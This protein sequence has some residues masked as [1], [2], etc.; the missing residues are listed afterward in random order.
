MA[1]TP[2][3]INANRLNAQRSTGPKSVEGKD[4]ARRNAL[5]HGLTGGGVVLPGEDEREVAIREAAFRDQLVDEGDALVGALVRQMAIAS[6]RV[7]DDPIGEERRG[8]PERGDRASI[9]SPQPN[10]AEPM[11]T[12]PAER[13]RRQSPDQHRQRHPEFIA[14]RRRLTVRR[15][16]HAAGRQ[17]QRQTNQPGASHRR[18]PRTRVAQNPD[19]SL[20]DKV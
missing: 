7:Q 18:S 16:T 6:I 4:A 20:S 19:G 11:A 15:L 2:A 3:Q 5:K 12:D 1:A 14:E 10:R 9:I 8:E 13:G 17:D